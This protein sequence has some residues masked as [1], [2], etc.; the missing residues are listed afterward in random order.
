MKKMMI[1]ALMLICAAIAVHAAGGVTIQG[2]WDRKE[3]LGRAKPGKVNLYRVE[4]G[5]LVEI[6]AYNTGKEGQFGFYFQPEQEGFY[7]I[8]AGTPGAVVDKYTFYFKKQDVLHI[9]VNDSSYTLTGEASNENKELARW[10]DFVLPLEIG[11]VYFMKRHTTYETFFPM[12]ENMAETAGAYQAK[13]TGNGRFDQAFVKFR[14]LDMYNFARMMLATP[15]TKHP[16]TEDLTAFYRNV[17]VAG[18]TRSADILQYPFGMDILMGLERIEKSIKGDQGDD[19]EK[20]L[21]AYQND[22]LKGEVVLEAEARLRTYLGFTEMNKTFGKYVVTEDQELR[23]KNI[24]AELAKNTVKPGTK[25]IDFSFPDVSG[26]KTALTDF[27]GKVVLLDVWA[28]WCG[29]CKAEIPALKALEKELRDKDIVFMSVSVDAAKDKQK[30]MDFVA[31][32]DLKGVQLFATNEN[33]LSKYYNIKGIPRFMVFDK[34]GNI[35]SLDAP[36]PSG[37]ELKTLLLEELKK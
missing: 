10:H 36:R 2:T 9:A 12:L 23:Q 3:A 37:T 18:L 35:V 7:V 13:K 33:E 8:G 28:T 24:I 34:K 22:T 14:Q 4:H 26:K 1:T 5:R 30:W 29:P 21:V 32:E 17:N 11:A 19:L 25:A 31:K 27:T 15:R 16:Q 6:S 20:R